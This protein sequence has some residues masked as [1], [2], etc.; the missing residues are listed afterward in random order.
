MI[1]V[2]TLYSDSYNLYRKIDDV[3]YELIINNNPTKYFVLNEMFQ[4]IEINKPALSIQNEQIPLD[5]VYNWNE[6]NVKKYLAVLHFKNYI[7]DILRSFYNIYKFYNEK[8]D[9]DININ[10]NINK[11]FNYLFR[12]ITNDYVSTNKK[13]DNIINF[14]IYWIY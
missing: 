12:D 1:G 5:I 6:K 9:Y 7:N 10:N 2:S 11:L 14:F 3:Y 8:K 13:P 4:I